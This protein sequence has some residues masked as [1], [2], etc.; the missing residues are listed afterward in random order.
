MFGASS[1]AAAEPVAGRACRACAD[2][3]GNALQTPIQHPLAFPA[4]VSEDKAWRICEVRVPD[5]QA[6]W[7]IA[8]CAIATAAA[9]QGVVVPTTSPSAPPIGVV[10]G[11]RG[12]PPGSSPSGN[13]GTATPQFL[14]GNVAIDNGAP[15]PSGIPI[16]RVCSITSRT[17]AYSD[18][19][20]HFTF[21]WGGSSG[22]LPDAS[23]SGSRASAGVIGILPGVAGAGGSSGSSGTGPQSPVANCELR[24]RLAGYRSDVISLTGRH[25][26]DSPDLGLIVLHHLGSGE[27]TA[28]SS[29]T[30]AAP[31]PAKAAY[32]KGVA[33]LHAG[34]REQGLK[35]LERA[36]KIYPRYADALIELG[37]AAGHDKKWAETVGYLDRALKLEPS[38]FPQAWY[39]DAMAHYYLQ[40][41]DAAETSVR[42]AVR[43][44]AQ[45]RNPRAGYVLGMILAQK[46]DYP[47]ATIEL[48]SYLQAAPNAPDL[49]QV[50]AQLA[51]IESIELEAGG[52]KK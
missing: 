29:N 41:Y 39:V 31:R 27:G 23:D 38:Q 3:A 44:D 47:A 17:V 35:E 21:R 25:D 2:V 43:L 7:L 22:E 12:L 52:V 14:S 28:V 45:H 33:A 48:R 8:V 36:V 40:D 51:Q 49:N 6:R 10:P 15:L 30:L 42:Q 32:E 5:T 20:G 26:T 9:Q 19:R 37:I 13:G 46:R 18:A 11:N 1:Y 4:P 24:A 50:K 34:H 16:E